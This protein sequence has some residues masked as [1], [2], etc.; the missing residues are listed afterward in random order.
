MSGNPKVLVIS[1]NVFSDNSNMGRTLLN[2]FKY[3]DKKSLA[4]LYFHSEVPGSNIC[5][6]YYR[7]TD[8]DLIRSIF[9]GNKTGTLFGNDD[10]ITGAKTNRIDSGVEA[11]IYQMGRKRTPFMYVGRN[12]LWNTKKW[13]NQQLDKWIENF[14]PDVVFFA[15]GD[16]TFS[17]DIALYIAKSRRIPLVISV[18]DDY[19]FNDRFSLSPLY[20]MNQILFK[21]KFKKTV[22]YASKGVYICDMLK[23]KYSNHFKCPAE[24]IM[25]LSGVETSFVKNNNGQI[26]V[27]Y[28]GNLSHGRWKSLVDI[29]R[30]L[31]EIGHEYRINVYSHETNKN[32]INY[33]NKNNGIEFKGAISYQE[34]INVMKNSD[35]LIHVEDFSKKNIKRVKYSVSTKI[36]DSLKCGTCL[37]A[38]G[39]KNV[40]SIDYLYRNSAAYVVNTKIE[41]KST[42]EELINNKVSRNRYIEKALN[43]ATER[44]DEKRNSELIKNVISSVLEEN[45]N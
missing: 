16:Y 19:V 36:A 32:I 28:L 1:H 13:H 33:M 43:L 15:S 2:Y 35:I 26:R 8:F 18:V 23:N 11:N 45:R 6:N 27:S 3:F 10:I 22:G 24:T 41:L 31:K 30:A 39:P 38:Y 4:N 5:G 34:V 44:H 20:W 9:K 40:A 17:Y 25:T 42:L 37:L 7:V 14:N 21:Q 29:G 12:I